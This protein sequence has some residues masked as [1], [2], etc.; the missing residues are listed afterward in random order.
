[1]AFHWLIPFFFNG[2]DE[3]A[4]ASLEA[5]MITRQ[6]AGQACVTLLCPSCSAIVM[7]KSSLDDLK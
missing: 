2:E 5:Q 1:M 7:E 4:Q 3:K 6:S